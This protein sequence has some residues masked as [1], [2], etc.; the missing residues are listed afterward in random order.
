M[1]VGGDTVTFAYTVLNRGPSSTVDVGLDVTVDSSMTVLR[2]SGGDLPCVLTTA[3]ASCGLGELAPGDSG[4]VTIDVSVSAAGPASATALVVSDLPDSEPSND[5]LVLSV[6]V[7]SGVG[8]GEPDEVPE[9]FALHQNYPNPFNP[10]TTISFDVA[11]PTEVRLKVFDILGREVA[12]LVDGDLAS[13]FH[14]VVFDASR[15]ASGMY[16]Y[17][18]EM[19]DYRGFRTMVLIR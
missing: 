7:T 18:I 11:Q 14:H 10:R 16:I 5:I 19:G 12:T 17:R 3:S 4:S 1:V 8:V 13:G 9:S 6:N 15:L 2:A